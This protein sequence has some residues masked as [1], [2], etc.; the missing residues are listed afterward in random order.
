MAGSIDRDWLEEKFLHLNT[1]L[2]AFLHRVDCTDRTISEFQGKHYKEIT[3]L[4]NRMGAQ[5]TK[6]EVHSQW[7][8]KH[9]KLE[10]GRAGWTQAVGVW[11]QVVLVAIGAIVGAIVT[12]YTRMAP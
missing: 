10:A 12:F 5:E 9:E 4:F 7:I 8:D 2:D 1:R 6:A 11:F 3:E